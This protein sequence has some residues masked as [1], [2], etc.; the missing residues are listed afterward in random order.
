MRRT[1][2]AES[3]RQI[4]NEIRLLGEGDVLLL[5]TDG[6]SERVGGKLAAALTP[7]IRSVAGLSARE[8]VHAL[9]GDLDRLGAPD[10]DTTLVAIKRTSP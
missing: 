6:A 10:D 5:Y 2:P 8:I 3:P 1:P 4:V 9:R 7:T